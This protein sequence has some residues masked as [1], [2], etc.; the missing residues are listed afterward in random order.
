MGN[1]GRNKQFFRLVE[2][3]YQVDLIV[4]QYFFDNNYHLDLIV[5]SL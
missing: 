3:D 5:F 2:I 1:Q 4:R